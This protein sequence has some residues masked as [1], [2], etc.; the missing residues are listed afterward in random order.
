[1]ATTVRKAT[2]ADIDFIAKAVLLSSRSEKK[3]GLFDLIFSS[4]SDDALIEWI[5]KLLATTIKSY[6]HLSNFLVSVKDTEVVGCV[7]GY[8]ARIANDDALSKALEQIGIDES[9]HERIA[10]YFLCAANVDKQTFVLD[11]LYVTPEYEGL[12][13]Y[14][15]LVGKAILNAKLRGYHKIQLSLDIGANEVIYKKLGFS[16]IDSKK[17]EYYEEVFGHSGIERLQMSL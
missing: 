4:N 3:I 5:K 15:E 1:M 10:V 8:E 14:K 2:E 7:C 13:I 17:S 16:V 6:C 9:Y 12:D 11:F